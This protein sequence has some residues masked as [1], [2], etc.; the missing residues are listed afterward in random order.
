MRIRLSDTNIQEVSN[1]EVI[2]GEE[3]NTG[4]W[5]A[6]V[7][8]EDPWYYHLLS[9]GKSGEASDYGCL[10]QLS[11]K[12]C[13][14]KEEAEAAGRKLVD[15]LYEKGCLDLRTGLDDWSFELF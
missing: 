15:Q 7:R 14:T 9:K 3:R 6:I 8:I 13:E 10:G 11:H 1:F 2:V 4:Q 5:Q 12:K